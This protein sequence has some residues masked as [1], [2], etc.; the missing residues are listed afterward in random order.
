MRPLRYASSIAALTLVPIL[1]AANGVS[2]PG[3]TPISPV[4]QQVVAQRPHVVVIVT[5]DQRT[6]SL[7]RMGAV[8]SELVGKGRLFTGAG[9]PTSLCCPARASILTGLFA[10]STQVYSNSYPA[11]G[12]RRFRDVGLEDR[13]LATALDAAGYRTGLVGKYLNG[14]ANHAPAG[15]EPPGWD[16]FVSFS[17]EMGYYD[18]ALTD[19]TTYGDR[20]ADYS[21]DVLAEYATR[22]IET[23]PADTPMFLYFAPWSPHRP[24]TPAPRHAGFW[25]DRMPSYDEPWVDENLA[26]KPAWIQG[27][28]P[29]PQLDIDR[30]LAGIQD[31][32]MAVDDAV[33]RLL[34]ALEATGRLENTLLIYLSDQG[35]AVGEHHLKVWKNLP[36]RFITEI[37]LVVRWDDAV[38]AGTTSSR[39][40]LNIDVAPTIAAAT[41]ISLPSEGLD[42]LGDRRRRGYPLEATYWKHGDSPP[43]HPA[44]CGFRTHRWMFAHYADGTEELYDYRTDPYELH[45]LASRPDHAGQLREMRR[46]AQ[47]TCYPVPPGFSW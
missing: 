45:N 23:T 12:W 10:H 22:F 37:P 17:S 21:T 15:Y 44:Y 1:V 3:T 28:E 46:K 29:R 36:Y 2:V 13:T 20:P 39:L 5:D 47:K 11:G 8:W 19:G 41:D 38:P 18:Y 43:R 16:S 34:T 27:R 4:P 33:A 30:D 42:L 14:F 35:T 24:F 26:D 25:A 6:D 7:P 31:N 32:L 40:A 9:A